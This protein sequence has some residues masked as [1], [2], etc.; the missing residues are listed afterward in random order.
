MKPSPIKS[1]NMSE[2]HV[3]MSLYMCQDDGLRPLC[4]LDV[5]HTACFWG[6]CEAATS[7]STTSANFNKQS[8]PISKPLSQTNSMIKRHTLGEPRGNLPFSFSLF[9]SFCLS[10]SLSFV[11]YSLIFSPDLEWNNILQCHLLDSTSLSPQR[12]HVMII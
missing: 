6:S 7:K 3:Y 9:H 8:P 5:F 11:L 12:Y 2:M 10:L 4:S 1:W